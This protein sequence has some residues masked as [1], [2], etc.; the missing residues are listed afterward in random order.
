[1]ASESVTPLQQAIRQVVADLT[2]ESIRFA[3]VGGLAVSIRAEPRLTRDIDFAVSVEDDVMAES[4]VRRL[5]SRGYIPGAVVNHASGRLATVRLELPGS[6][7]IDLLFSSCGIESEIVAAAERLEAVP[8]LEI[9]VAT[10]GHLMA[11][12]LLARDDR[13]RPADADD[14]RSL[15]AVATDADWR[16]ARTAVRLITERGYSR[17]R[18]LMAGLDELNDLVR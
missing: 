15:A 3:L 8:G 4:I 18:D 6:L 7:I 11:M 2:A 14:L 5:G 16:Q 13:Q 10:T 17:D 12:K 1:M 9:P